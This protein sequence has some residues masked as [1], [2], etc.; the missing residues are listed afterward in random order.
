MCVCVCTV[1]L[2]TRGL[3]SKQ[4]KS[5]MKQKKSFDSL[6]LY[7]VAL[8]QSFSLSLFSR[9]AEQKTDRV[10]KNYTFFSIL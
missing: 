1:N 10:R 5:L 4:G 6:I 7:S 8:P 9:F 2:I 3:Y